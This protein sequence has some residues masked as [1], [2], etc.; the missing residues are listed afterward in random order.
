MKPGDMVRFTRN[1]VELS[2][3]KKSRVYLREDV[4]GIVIKKVRH[5][6]DVWIVMFPKMGGVDGYPA[7]WLEVISEDDW[8]HC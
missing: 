4:V 8:K 7:D 6:D 2:H 1:K 3:Y 5:L